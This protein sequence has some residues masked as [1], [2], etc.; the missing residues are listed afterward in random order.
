[1]SLDIVSIAIIVVIAWRVRFFI[2]LTERSN[3]ETLTLAIILVLALYYVVSTFK[4]FVG[5]LHMLWLNAPAL[6]TPGDVKQLRVESR[7]HKAMKSGGSS[8]SA[9]F[10]I[11]V[12][13]QGKPGQKLRWDV[14]DDVGK[15]GE[16]VLDGVKATYYP[17]KGEMNNSIFEF[18]ASD[19]EKAMKKTNQAAELQI[20]QWSTI[21][22]DEASSYFSMASAF[23]NLEAQLGN[24]GTLWPTV[25]IGEDDVQ[26]IGRDL[27]R[28]APALRNE[29]LLPDLEYAVEYNVP[30]LPEPLGFIK[31]TRSDNR[32]DPVITMGCA[33]LVM[34]VTMAILT[35]FILLPPWVP[36]K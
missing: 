3:V 20:V 22:Q 34:V 23:K 6:W 32:A 11:A 18:L 19:L 4:G 29:A 33:G 28:L 15:L 9:Y 35:F 10:D 8:K 27:T 17:T 21:D 36:S 30:V 2:T 26:E 5:A 14:G 16:I 25:Q 31:L 12:E 1:M 7:K 13:L 24:K